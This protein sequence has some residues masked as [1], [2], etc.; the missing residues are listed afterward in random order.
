MPTKR[1]L[2]IWAY[3]LI[4]TAILVLVIV[5]ARPVH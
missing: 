3:W 5:V 4:A 2:P 1:E